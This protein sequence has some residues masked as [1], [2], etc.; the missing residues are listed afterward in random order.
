[1]E[2][3]R[4][5]K[6]RSSLAI[7]PSGVKVQTFVESRA[8]ELQ[9]LHSVISSR[10][11]NNFKSQQNKRR[12]TSGF[13]NRSK[14]KK[15]P[16][17]N[18]NKGLLGVLM[19]DKE[20]EDKKNKKLPRRIRRRMELRRNPESGFSTSGDGTKRLRTHLW[21]SKRFSMAKLWGYYL[22]VGLPGR[23]KGSRALLKWCKH[24]TLIHDASYNTAVQLEG[25]EDSLLSILRMVLVPTPGID[26]ELSTST[27]SGTTYGSAMLH[28]VGAPFSQL[29]SPVIYMWRPFI[30]PSIDTGPGSNQIGSGSISNSSSM[31]SSSFRHL[32]VWIH[33]GALTEALGALRIA[34]QKQKDETGISVNCFSRGGQ[35]A[36]LEVMGSKGIQLL[37]KILQPVPETSWS[38]LELTRSS[39][40][41]TEA[42]HQLEG[43]IILKHA[44][45]LP[46]NAV[47]S[48]KVKDPRHLDKDGP[49]SVSEEASESLAGD[50]VKD[51]PNEHSALTA[52]PNQNE[53]IISSFLLDSEAR[54]FVC[55]DS[56]ELWD[57]HSG[58]NPPVDEN[59]LCMEKH[60]KR[61]DFFHLDKNTGMET[62]T[63]IESRSCPVVLL[64]EGKGSHVRWTI[65][66]PLSWVKAFWLPLVNHGAH[67]VG[68]RERRWVA[69]D[70]RL[71]S[72]PYDF[73]DCKTYSCFMAAESI[74][75]DEKMELRPLAMRP[76]KVPIPPP[77]ESVRHA[78]EDQ[79]TNVGDIQDIHEEKNACDSL[80]DIGSANSELEVLA[81]GDFPFKGFIAR[82]SSILSCH[83]KEI[84][85]GHLLL[86]PNEQMGKKTTL[87]ENR[88]KIVP[89][90]G[91]DCHLRFDRKLCFVRVIIRA[92]REGAFEEGSVVCAPHLTDISL[93]KSRSVFVFW[94]YLLLRSFFF[95]QF[96]FFRL[97]T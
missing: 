95:V 76:L 39:V 10:L 54:K 17:L 43:S 26:Q 63:N 30:R 15:R 96:N 73:P 34:C 2:K 89:G 51:E 7:P 59:L 69:C 92:Y 23:G 50:G 65:I 3:E 44:I 57:I 37:Q 97:S 25:P 81:Q 5:Y 24:G 68:L 83:L 4:R 84:C 33:A 70:V 42:N 49:K 91:G 86:Y 38:S 71:P 93:L 75:S 80:D 78:F 53:K 87:L 79:I 32:W 12:R 67:A 18:N 14:S 16:R 40:V 41:E 60:Q 48:L 31:C 58:V 22:P 9:S 6:K 82:T 55:S 72:F 85:G 62:T 45:H 52:C 36:Q 94:L 61:V 21:L 47:V 19:S 1:M 64:K 29:I 35:L 27:L 8:P 13:N 66:L 56:K 28:H 88:D 46:D 20:E 77:W 11:D 90:P 74:A